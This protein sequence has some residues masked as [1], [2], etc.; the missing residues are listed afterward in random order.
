MKTISTSKKVL[1]PQFLLVFVTILFYTVPV[2]ANM[3]HIVNVSDF[4]FTPKELQI[5]V[6]DTVEWQNTQGYH[7]V[8]GKTATYP[9]NP[10]SF[11]TALGF[12]WTYIF[13][14][15]LPGKYTYRCDPHIQSNM[16]GTIEVNESG[17]DDDNKYDLTINFTGMTPHVG[18]TLQLAL[19][20]K[21]SGM[22]IARKKQIV[23]TEFSLMV[24]GIEKDHSYNV[25]FFADHN[26]NGKY[27][28]PNADH[29]WRMEL[30][31]VMGDT[32]L[33]FQHNTNFT[34]I[35]WKNKLTVHFMGMTPHVGQTLQLA[36]IDKNS[37]MEVQRVATVAAADFMVD[38]YG[39][40][41]GMS[42]NVDFFAD[43]NKNGQY[44]TPNADHAWRMELNDVM[45]DTTL[46]FQH[47]T[48]F[49]DIMWKNKLTVH[50][51]GM[52]PHV[53]QTLQLAVI[54]KNSGM[55]V[56]R[57][58]TVAAADFMV[59]VF[60]IE[61]GMSYNVDFFADH[62]K[63]GQYDAPPAD[64]AWRM[65]LNDVMGDTT[66]M[67][68]HNTN[69]TDIM[70]KNKLTV[71]FMGMTPH[72]GQ[73]LQL[74]VI[75]KNSGMEVQRV[76]TVA[77]ADFM[78]DVYG[79][80]NGMSYNVDF[81]ADHNKNGKYDAPNADHAWRMELNDVMGDTTLM[82]QH[83]TNFTDINWI[84]TAISEVRDLSLRMYPN[85]A[86]DK[87]FIEMDEISGSEIQ[88]SVFDITGKLKYQQIKPMNNKIEI[89]VQNFENGIY[90]ISV[91]T[92]S[93]QQM[94]KL[95]KY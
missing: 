31:D 75:D 27:D 8:N 85:P 47:N 14:F 45:G 9:S 61:N 57:V 91:K 16:V 94:L 48:N 56:Q 86:T 63:N 24:S 3:K 32:T 7:N 74:A 52:T 28:A 67:F 83:N 54:D 64:H 58:A 29:A 62:N 43:H 41:N 59:D 78:V 13:V 12:G 34:D 18:Q 40:E 22:E 33:M 73:T 70:W 90:L 4:K 44:D 37:G 17:G 42:Y 65:E 5:T 72:V 82:F 93:K 77:A 92:N 10:E 51:M 2:S 49:T 95:I 15:N 6:G 39:I 36:V 25:D 80:E 30:N 87:V 88:V 68:Q 38:V 79:I 46:M 50:F 89:E 23:S 1:I 35:M 55:E 84:T 69:F 21:D 11:E 26:K 53:G 71:H 19:I 20:D 76:A 66:L 60:G 81:F